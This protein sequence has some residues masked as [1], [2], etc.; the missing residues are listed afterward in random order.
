M[1]SGSVN[2]SN[3]EFNLNDEWSSG[4]YENID[5]SLDD[6]IQ[7]IEAIQSRVQQLKTR[8]EMVICENRGKSCSVTQLSMHEP[9]DGFNHF[10]EKSS[11][12]AGNRNTIPFSF[13]HSSTH[14][15]SDFHTEDLLMHGNAPASREG[16]IPCIE[17]GSGPGLYVHVQ[18]SSSFLFFC[19]I[20]I[21][22]A[23]YVGYA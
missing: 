13:P 22:F 11:S 23:I 6:I 21:L 20:L 1:I 4:E 12:F 5:K 17:T 3:K 8:T 16:I 10:D 18:V 15:Q 2:D 7:K 14:L 9:S 19:H